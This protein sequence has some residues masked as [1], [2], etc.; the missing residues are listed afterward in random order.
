MRII[1][2]QD[3]DALEQY[4]F[5][6]SSTPAQARVNH[7]MRRE[8]STPSI[9]ACRAKKDLALFIGLKREAA[10]HCLIRCPLN[11]GSIPST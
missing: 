1:V 3:E 10:Y 5:N 6:R 4:F 8:T 2:R 11:D 7:R 9:S